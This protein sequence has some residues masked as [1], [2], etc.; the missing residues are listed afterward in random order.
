MHPVPDSAALPE[1]PAAEPKQG[2]VNFLAVLGFGV[3]L[4]IV[5]GAIHLMVWLLFDYFDSR[6]AARV[7]PAYPLAIGAS[8]RQPPEP[9]L[10]INPREDLR[11]L[12][13]REDDVLNNYGWVDRQAGVV[14]IPIEQA[15]RITAQRG[16]PWQQEK[17][18]P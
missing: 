16:L 5:A 7:V 13:A 18:T 1:R 17:R 4:V 15:L 14:R 10:Q 8:D 12:R 11:V 3:G 9:R 6:E 2:E